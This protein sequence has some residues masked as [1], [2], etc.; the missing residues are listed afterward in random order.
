MNSGLVERIKAPVWKAG[1]HLCG[2]P[3][4]R[5]PYPLP[6]KGENVMPDITYLS[7]EDIDIL[8]EQANEKMKEGYIPCGFQVVIAPGAR[9]LQFFQ[10]M[11]KLGE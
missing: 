8:R 5:I 1:D 10:A 2:G 3:W 9:Y 7:S 4:V 11:Y 6:I